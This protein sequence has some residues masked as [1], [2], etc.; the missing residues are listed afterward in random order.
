MPLQAVRP[1]I[2]GFIN[3]QVSAWLMALVV[4]LGGSAL[5]IIV[6]WATSDLYQQQGR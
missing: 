6:A 4:F 1:K 2:L 3:E 5:T